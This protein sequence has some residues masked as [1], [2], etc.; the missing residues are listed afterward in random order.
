MTSFLEEFTLPYVDTFLMLW[1]QSLCTDGET[2]EVK[3]MHLHDK[4]D[5]HPSTSIS[6]ICFYAQHDDAPLWPVSLSNPKTAVKNHHAVY[7]HL[8]QQFSFPDTKVWK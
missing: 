1:S 4:Y 7:G 2:V 6:S 8:L 3:L 5:I